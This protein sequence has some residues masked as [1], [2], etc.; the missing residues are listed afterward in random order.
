[1]KNFKF[2]KGRFARFMSSKGFYAAIAVCL[3]G[4]GVATWLAVDRTIT[5]IEDSNS[6]MIDSD[7]SFSEFPIVEEVEKKVPKIPEVSTPKVSSSSSTSSTPPSSSAPASV[8]EEPSAPVEGP[9][10]SPNLVYTLPV[11]GDIVNQYSNGELVKNMTLGDWR[12]HDGVDIAAEV[13]ADIYAIADGAVEEIRHDALWGT[14]LT[15]TH[16]DGKISIYA[17]LS[18]V[19]PVKEGDM[20]LAKSVIGR[21]DGVPCEMSDESHLHFSMKQD[22]AWMDPLTVMAKSE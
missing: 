8:P 18:D 17:G 11:K 19:V 16:I 14:V 22:N 15:L 10:P 12:T 6:R 13:G 5:G 20:V 4:A 9:P 1:M 21:L 3:V 2:S 7:T